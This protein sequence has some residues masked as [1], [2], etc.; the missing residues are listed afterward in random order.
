MPQLI[1]N[2]LYDTLDEFFSN[3]SD[4]SLPSWVSDIVPI[5]TD[6]LQTLNFFVPLDTFLSVTLTVFEF[7]VIL[8]AFRFIWLKKIRWI[9]YLYKQWNEYEEN[10][11]TNNFDR[12]NIFP[13]GVIAQ[14][15]LFNV[16]ECGKFQFSIFPRVEK[17][18]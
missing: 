2:N 12:G 8:I 3:F 17:S 1:L 6:T 10:A 14:T 18:D 11:A 9:S 4:W 16:W 7:N 5:L 13:S 15:R